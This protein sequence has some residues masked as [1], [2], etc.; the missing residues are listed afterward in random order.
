MSGSV[1]E[2]PRAERFADPAHTRGQ[3]LR[4]GLLGGINTALTAGAFYL[5]AWVLPARAAF[6]VVYVAGLAFV[7]VTTPRYVFGSRA[8]WAKRLL[9]GAWYVGVYVIGLGAVSLLSWIDAPRLL[10]VLGTVAVTAPL[11]FLGARVIVGRDY[12]GGGSTPSG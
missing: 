1:V 7:M 2:G 9:L 5:L 12:S 3:V 11:S 6:T 10:V 4:F 8:T